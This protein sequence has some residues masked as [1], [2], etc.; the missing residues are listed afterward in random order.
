MRTSANRFVRLFAAGV[1]L[2]A[3]AGAAEE[4]SLLDRPGWVRT[5]D[6][7]QLVWNDGPDGIEIPCP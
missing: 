6:K 2:L 1:A 5:C 7:G 4:A 3:S